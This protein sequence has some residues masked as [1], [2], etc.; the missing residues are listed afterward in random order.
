MR[1]PSPAPAMA[2][3]RSVSSGRLKRSARASSPSYGC[4]RYACAHSRDWAISVM[5]Q[6]LDE[7]P[8]ATS[9]ALD[10]PMAPAMAID[11]SDA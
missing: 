11:T 1:A 10:H 6:S 4:L 3:A 8:A 7:T 9:R 5:A 2:R